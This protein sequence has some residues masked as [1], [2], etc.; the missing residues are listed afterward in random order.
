MRLARFVTPEGRVGVGRVAGPR[1]AEPLIAGTLF[2][3]R[4][5]VAPV[6]VA[7]W[8]AP[9]EPPNIL[10]VG[11]NYRRHAAETAAQLPDHPLIFLKATTSVAHPDDPIV[12]PLSAPDEVDFEAE[13]AVVVGRETRRVSEAAALEYVLGFTCANDVS[14]RDCQ[15]RLDRQWARGKSFDTFCPLGPWIVTRDELDPDHCDIALRLNGRTMQSSN[16]ADMIFSTRAL[17]SYLSHQFTLPPGTV[18]L[19]GT[20]EGVGTARTPPVYLREGDRVEVDIRGI[21]VLRNVVARE[22]EAPHA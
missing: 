9:V 15:K 10:A 22:A 6:P 4:E 17:V 3:P 14:A 21:G 20:P 1:Q 12:L 8:L 7:R 2:N 19:T 18:I 16:T 11:L 5:F 13:L